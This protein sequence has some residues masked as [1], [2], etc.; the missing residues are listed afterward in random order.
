MHTVQLLLG[1]RGKTYPY[2][3]GFVF[4]RSSMARWMEMITRYYFSCFSVR[5]LR[6]L[7]RCRMTVCIPSI[8]AGFLI[9]LG[10][11]LPS[12]SGYCY[13]WSRSQCTNKRLDVPQVLDSRTMANRSRIQEM[14]WGTY[15]P[16]VYFG[17]RPRLPHSV[18][19]GILW[20]VYSTKN[21]SSQIRNA[22]LRHFCK[23]DDHL[24]KYGWQYHDGRLFGSQEIIDGMYR[25][26]T[27]FIK[28]PLGD[29]GGD[30]TARI[31]GE[32]Q[33]KLKKSSGFSLFFY[34]AN[35]GDGQVQLTTQGDSGKLIGINGET[36]DL[37]AF[38]FA[39]PQVQSATSSYLT[40]RMNRLENLTNFVRDHIKK[41]SAA[42]NQTLLT[43]KGNSVDAPDLI[44]YQ[45]QL[46]FPFQLDFTFESA[47]SNRKQAH[48]PTGFA[49]DEELVKH[50]TDF[51]RRFED[52]F[53]LEKKGFN[54]SYISFARATLSNLIGGIG[55]FY[56]QSLVASEAVHQSMQYFPAPL[57]TA[58]PS[59]SF[60]PRGFLWDE[61]FHQLVVLKWDP[62]ITQDVLAHWLDLMNADGWIP[63]EQILGGEAR[64]RV[65][66]EFIV[67]H[68]EHGNP[69]SLFITIQA[70]LASHQEDRQIDFLKAIFPRLQAWFRWFSRTQRGKLPTTYYWRGRNRIDR[71]EVNPKTLMSGLDDYP[72][73]SHPSDIE[74]HLD[75][76]C[77]MALGSRVMATVAKKIGNPTFKEYKRLE[78]QLTDELLLT[79]LH[80]Y[81][82][83]N[84]FCD[85]GNH[86]K[87]ALQ[88]VPVQVSSGKTI[89][90]TMIVQRKAKPQFISEFGYMSLF[91]LFTKILRPSSDKLGIILSQLANKSIL[92]SE[93]G[94][95][96]ISKRSVFYGR[97]NT[98][99]D[100]PY[101]RGAIWLNMNYLAVRSLHHY[102]HTNGPYQDRA[103]RLYQEL[104][105]NLIDNLVK[106]YQQTGYV[107][108]SYCDEP[109]RFMLPRSPLSC[110]RKG[111][112]R[113]TH[114]F[115]G[116][117][118]LILLI[119]SETY[120]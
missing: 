37:G 120:D 41:R 82:D 31:S 46:T 72:R 99:H 44:I 53:G 52:T 42:Y 51:D 25:L 71:H 103:K 58:V 115:T 7:S 73:A 14:L 85:Y 59:R 29:F 93:Y 23:D 107:W 5:R 119:M 24:T 67:Q 80:W 64:S 88:T 19:A 4:N 112:G 100:P 12:S 98:R 8:V 18:V 114:P 109:D 90:H 69:P 70:L 49:F 106:E 111:Q 118:S 55:Y 3:I 45:L 102:A 113:G 78:S 21:S 50:K 101:W 38:H 26:Q 13:P 10:F 87:M 84:M 16:H 66:A 2:V 110:L 57:Y 32:A 96:S 91:P 77:W 108:E 97:P 105:S 75:L 27:D 68:A 6:R 81:D 92:W 9:V 94:L 15:R 74:R 89:N 63:R 36:R 86:S 104:R 60:F 20:M 30:W 48:P 76:R 65:P 1:L 79:R 61:G 62:C 117:S 33:G 56:G 35:E 34:V 11:C 17:L 40:A 116:W 39:F 83:S 54:S 95:R 28:R 43:I 47:S 22:R